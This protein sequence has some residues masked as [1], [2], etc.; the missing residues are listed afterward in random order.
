MK[1]AACRDCVYF[2]P[3]PDM[4]PPGVTEVVGECRAGPPAA[5]WVALHGL[6]LKRLPTVG[7]MHEVTHNVTQTGG[8]P[9][10]VESVWCGDF[11]ANG[12]YIPSLPV[13]KDGG[14]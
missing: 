11:T 9:V 12:E 10:V 1:D 5:S 2:V 13:L 3:R 8:F 6:R 14:H 4:K 7:D